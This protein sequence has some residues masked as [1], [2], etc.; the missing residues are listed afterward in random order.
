MLSK[1]KAIAAKLSQT[2]PLIFGIVLGYLG[3]P[4]ISAGLNLVKMFIKVVTE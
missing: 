3:H 1:L 2:E 4:L